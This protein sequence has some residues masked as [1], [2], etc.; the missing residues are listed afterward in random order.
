MTNM[1]Q[2]ARGWLLKTA[3]ENYWR[4]A[5]IC[6]FDDLVQ[7]GGLVWARIVNRYPNVTDMPHRMALFKRAFINRIHDLSKKATKA[8]IPECDLPNPISV[9]L[10]QPDPDQDVDLALIIEQLPGSIRRLLGRII[11]DPE[12]PYRR[13]LDH[14]RETTNRRLCRLAGIDNHTGRDLH[15]ALLQYFRGVKL[16]PQ[17]D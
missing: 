7:E 16:H 10:E 4:V 14:T 2:G 17:Y 12:R 15:T 11:E 6:D 8:D 9:L 1:D 3:R 13:F 5:T